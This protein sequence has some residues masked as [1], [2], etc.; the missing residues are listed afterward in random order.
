MSQSHV[1]PKQRF[2]KK[3][4]T[5]WGSPKLLQLLIQLWGLGSSL[6]LKF[7]FRV[8]LNSCYGRLTN[9]FLANRG[10]GKTGA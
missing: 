2:A 1:L 10:F 8:G 5:C 6:V 4:K 7:V 3:G 9:S